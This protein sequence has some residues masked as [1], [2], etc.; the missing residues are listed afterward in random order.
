M[1]SCGCEASDRKERDEEEDEE[2]D[3]TDHHADRDLGASREAA[4][5][6]CAAAAVHRNEHRQLPAL[7]CI[8]SLV[9]HTLGIGQRDRDRLQELAGQS[10][11]W[12]NDLDQGNRCAR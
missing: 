8:A 5:A 10:S 9:E 11:R 1:R 12:G 6:L 4:L 3:H 2:A 7:L